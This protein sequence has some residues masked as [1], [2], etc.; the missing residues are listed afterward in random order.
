MATISFLNLSILLIPLSIVGYFYYKYTN[1]KK[2]I[3]T[4]T[5]RMFLQLTLI[6]YFL[7][8]IFETKNMIMGGF[9][10]TFMLI[11]AS[12]IILRNTKSRDFVAYRDIIISTFVS[13]FIHINLILYVVLELNVFYEPRYVIPIAG[14]A[15]SNIM[16]VI[17]LAI[18]RFETEL[19]NGKS[20]EE[21]REISFKACMIPQINTLLAVGLV[22]LPGMMTGQILSGVDPLVAVRYQIMIMLMMISSGGFSAI[23]YYYLK[24]KSHIPNSK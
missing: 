18:E 2:E 17:S 1:D 14:M 5:A 12:F 8:V 11:S 13:A 19:E 9:I 7:I 23:I 24:S 3:V 6:G 20:F 21:A 4:A 16:N 22:S 10:L 15:F